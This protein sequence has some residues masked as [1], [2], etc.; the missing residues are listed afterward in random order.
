LK[1][2]KGLDFIITQTQSIQEFIIV[3]FAKKLN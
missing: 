2:Y 3:N 1:E